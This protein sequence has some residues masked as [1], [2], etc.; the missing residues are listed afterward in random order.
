[1]RGRGKTSGRLL[2]FATC[3]AVTHVSAFAEPLVVR[4]AKIGTV[5]ALPT[6]PAPGKDAVCPDTGVQGREAFFPST[7]V[8]FTLPPVP[9]DE[10]PPGCVSAEPPPPP[11]RPAAP[12]VF[13]L[14]AVPV[15]ASVA[16]GKWDAG[17]LAEINGVPGPWDELLGEVR[18]IPGSNSLEMVNRWVN[19]HVRYREDVGGDV[20]TG[21]VETMQ[22]GYGDC[23]DFAIAK[24]ALL[25]DLGI[26]RED[27]FLVLVRERAHNQDHA[28]L[29]VRKDGALYILD[30]R[31]DQMDRAEDVNDYIPTF[32]YSGRFAWVYGRR[33]R[34]GLGGG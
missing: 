16:M 29:A 32:G 15:G 18:R 23:E 1:M 6:G 22:R 21:A 33:L 26:S 11:P 9:A 25:A 4:D 2:M 28:V 12:D 7:G 27:M 5:N 34:D 3:I 31:V 24:M 10:L 8:T 14:S 13:G 17:R 30:S 20:W 19:W